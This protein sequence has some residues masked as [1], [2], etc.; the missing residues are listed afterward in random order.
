MIQMPNNSNAGIAAFMATGN[1]ADVL[2]TP[3]NPNGISGMATDSVGSPTSTSGSTSNGPLGG[4]LSALG[5]VLGAIQNLFGGSSSA[6]SAASTDWSGL[7]SEQTVAAGDSPMYSTTL[8]SNGT[9]FSSL[10][11]SGID[12]AAAAA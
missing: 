5:S 2:G 9:S 8:G 4:V 10:I 12:D 7:T 11:S 6:Q 3:A 1:P